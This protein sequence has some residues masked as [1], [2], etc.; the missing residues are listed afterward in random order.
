MICKLKTL[1]G[2]CLPL[3]LA[4][5]LGDD[6][7]APETPRT[8]QRVYDELVSLHAEGP[9]TTANHCTAL[10][11]GAKACGGPSGYVPLSVLSPNKEMAMSLASENSTL[12]RKEN[13]AGSGMSDCAFVTE[14]PLHCVEEKCVLHDPV[15]IMPVVVAP[16]P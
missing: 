16:T 14:P 12:S 13:Q 7:A 8:A 3:A 1:M 15:E 6:S 2:F 11:V 9:C 5:C 4:G 10:P